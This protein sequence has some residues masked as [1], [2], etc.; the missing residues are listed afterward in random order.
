MAVDELD[1]VLHRDDVAG[2][3]LVDLVDHG[4]ERGALARAGG[5]RDENQAAGLI[6]EMG[7]HGGQPEGVER[8]DVER[9]LPDYHGDAPALLEP[10]AAEPGQVLNAEGEAELVFGLEA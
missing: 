4:R 10:V 1:R 7:D 6:G 9:N 5:A 3:L 8:L 2:Q